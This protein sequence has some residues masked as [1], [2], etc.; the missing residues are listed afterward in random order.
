MNLNKCFIGNVSVESFALGNIST[1]TY[2]GIMSTMINY[3]PHRSGRIV[4]SSEYKVKYQ[5]AFF[6][7]VIDTNR[8]YSC[9]TNEVQYMKQWW[10]V[11]KFKTEVQMFHLLTEKYQIIKVAAPKTFNVEIFN[12]PGMLSEVLLPLNQT[13]KTNMYLTS[14]FQCVIYL[15]IKSSSYRLLNYDFFS[16]YTNFETG[17]DKMTTPLKQI[18]FPNARYSTHPIVSILKL[19]THQNYFLNISNLKFLYSDVHHPKQYDPLKIN[20]VMSQSTKYFQAIFCDFAGFV[21][22]N[23]VN[24]S[25]EKISSVCSFSPKHQNIYSSTSKVLLAMYMY[26]EYEKVTIKMT[27]SITHCSLIRINTCTFELPCKFTDGSQC[28]YLQQLTN[29]E[30][31]CIEGSFQCNYGRNPY[32]KITM[33]LS[34]CIVFQLNHNTNHYIKYPTAIEILLNWF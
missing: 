10:F 18:K 7:S 15:W 23:V 19:T 1:N 28:S 11:P 27:V 9:P 13:D 32:S 2:C 31:N 14:A 24:N 3:P 20:Y 4:I 21:A 34:Q 30:S 17:I 25:H 29:F 22:Y 12:G 26:P 33:N 6:Y 16:K 5:V 8:M